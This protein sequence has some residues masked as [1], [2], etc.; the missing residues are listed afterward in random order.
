L[1]RE[2]AGRKN[3]PFPLYRVPPND[4]AARILVV[5]TTESILVSTHVEH[6]HLL[7]N[8]L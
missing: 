7:K 1:V 2:R 3:L 8:M 5:K 6:L 4:L